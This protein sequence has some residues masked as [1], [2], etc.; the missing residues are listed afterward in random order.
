MY[1]IYDILVLVIAILYVPIIMVVAHKSY[2]QGYN[3]GKS[4]EKEKQILHRI[5]SRR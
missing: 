1:E 2:S 5:K 3:Q 4:D